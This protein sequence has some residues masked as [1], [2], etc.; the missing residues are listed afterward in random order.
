M[1]RKPPVSLIVLAVLV[2]CFVE[3]PAARPALA[4]PP[5][6]ALGFYLESK[7]TANAAYQALGDRF[8]TD[9]RMAAILS[10]LTTRLQ[11]T[12]A[13]PVRLQEC[14]ETNAAYFAATHEI[15]LCYQLF[16]A[17]KRANEKVFTGKPSAG[18]P[19]I[20]ELLPADQ[21][22]W[23]TMNAM[24]FFAMHEIGHCLIDEF[25]V[26][27]SGKE[28]DAV[29]E[30]ATVM[31]LAMRQ[32]AAAANGA[33]ALDLLTP[34]VKVRR[35]LGLEAFW[36]AHAFGE[37]RYADIM[38]LIYG[39]DPANHGAMVPQQLPSSRALRCPQEYSTKASSW[40][41]K[42]APHWRTN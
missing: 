6:H 40:N 26:K 1:L 9:G 36:D 12:R 8:V 29:D 23:M 15:V 10:A 16:D 4:Q 19:D 20:R 34:M 21:I 38:C 22:V 18:K 24:L 33:T 39:S 5:P 11:M 28:E 31:L 25:A 2:A 41:E 37:Q 27:Y 14:S 17:T 32:E 30:F 3:L 13:I 42:L 35:D 7:P